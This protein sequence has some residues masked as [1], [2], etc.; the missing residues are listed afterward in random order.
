MW[1]VWMKAC[2]NTTWLYSPQV[3][4]DDG[5]QETG[6][7]FTKYTLEQGQ[8]GLQTVKVHEFQPGSYMLQAAQGAKGGAVPSLAAEQSAQE[9][10]VHGK[11]NTSAMCAVP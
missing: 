1:V 2:T 4:Y 8:A 11:L 5:D 6:A 7:A 3:Q 9:L 10:H